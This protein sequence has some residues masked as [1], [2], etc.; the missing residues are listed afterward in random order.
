MGRPPWANKPRE[1]TRIWLSW[2]PIAYVVTPR[3]IE[4]RYVSVAYR[5]DDVTAVA[6]GLAP[7]ERVAVSAP[8]DAD[9]LLAA[10]GGGTE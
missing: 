7:G 3:G 2:R 4:P 9:Q 8:P 5:N 10:I 1:G 6:S